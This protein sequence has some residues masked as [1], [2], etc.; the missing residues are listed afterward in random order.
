MSE[1]V[2][3]ER[4]ERFMELQ[5]SISKK[6]LATKI[7]TEIEAI[8]DTADTESIVARSTGDAPEIDGLVYVESSRNHKPGD[9]I[10]VKIVASDDYDLYGIAAD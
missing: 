2:K 1:E 4:W 9:L 5:Q 10:T 7:G 6:K 8:V 3:Q